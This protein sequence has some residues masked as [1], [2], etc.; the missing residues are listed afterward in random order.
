MLELPSSPGIK[1]HMLEND[2]L[3]HHG[4]QHHVVEFALDHATTR[5]KS[6]NQ[7]IIQ[8]IERIPR[9]VLGPA[10]TRNSFF[11]KK[12]LLYGILL[13]IVQV[14]GL[15]YY[16]QADNSEFD[17]S[18]LPEEGCPNWTWFP[19]LVYLTAPMNFVLFL[20]ATGIRMFELFSRKKPEHFENGSKVKFQVTRTLY[21]QLCEVIASLLLLYCFLIFLALIGTILTPEAF[22]CNK[23]AP[24][25]YG[26]V[27]V[28]VYIGNLRY[29]GV[30]T[31]FREHI[32]MQLGAFKESNQTGDVRSHLARMKSAKS[33]IRKRLYKAAERC[34]CQEVQDILAEARRSIGDGFIKTMYSSTNMYLGFWSFSHKNPLHVAASLGDMETLKVLYNAGFDINALDKVSR[35]RFSTSD[36]FWF[37]AR[38]VVTR[39]WVAVESDMHSKATLMTP[40]HCAVATSQVEAVRWLVEEKKAD[41]NIMTKSPFRADRLPPLFLAEHPKIVEILLAAGANHLVVPDPGYINCITALELAYLRENYAVCG[42][43]EDWGSDIALTPMHVAAATGDVQRLTHFLRMHVD[44]NCLG[45]QGYIGVKCRTPLHWAA[46]NGEWQSV[47]ILLKG[48]AD[49][50]FQDSQGRSP[51]HWAVRNNKCDVVEVLF[52]HGCDVNLLDAQEMTPIICAAFAERIDVKLLKLL[53]SNGANI[54]HQVISGDTALHIAIKHEKKDTAVALVSCGANIMATNYEGYRAIDIATSTSLQFAIKSAAGY[55]DVMISYTHS[56]SEFALKLRKALEDSNITAWLDTMDPS[57]IGGGSVW[58]AEIAKGITNATLL[59]AIVTEDY[60]RSDWCL[61]ELACAK[62]AGTPILPISTEH[63]RLNEEMQVYLYTRQI[64]PFEPA[65][66]AINNT[67]PRNVT[68]EYDD[69]AFQ[70]QFRL[71]LDGIRDEVEKKRKKAL[72]TLKTMKSTVFQSNPNLLTSMRSPPS[73]PVN[74]PMQSLFNEK[75]VFIA[76]GDFN[77]TFVKRLQYELTTNKKVPCYLDSNVMD[78]VSRVKAAKE[79][80]LHCAC[81]I[82]VLSAKSCRNEMLN[83]QLAFAE[84]KGKPIY[85]VILHT[86]FTSLPSNQLY[87]LSRAPMHHFALEL[88]FATSFDQLFGDLSKHVDFQTEQD[89]C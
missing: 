79:A 63:A 80:I 83:D 71:L 9:F 36:L 76:H 45:E 58:R 64:V 38:F 10:Y 47:S 4:A 72:R 51:L 67:N 77:V 14:G 24:I 50:N 21:L 59:V 55:R 42:V 34:N 53:V 84:D 35:V 13:V 25:I 82:V 62:N 46:I 37:F 85:P 2:Q 43:L 41:V 28:C 19:I 3:G 78:T 29:V 18:E 33:T 44:P 70:L 56:H 61:K 48:G 1:A 60:T 30:F 89:E 12:L 16:F 27:G 81:V 20:P 87:S 15:F 75:F 8:M 17:V 31:R 32:K 23:I 11:A 22:K 86:D 74:Q 65:I 54:N 68:Y 52:K 73:T 7:H 66:K 49:P 5:R 26:L 40:L 88:G 57:G 6:S 69:N 39:P